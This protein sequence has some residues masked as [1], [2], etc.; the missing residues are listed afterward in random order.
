MHYLFITF[1]VFIGFFVVETFSFY[2]IFKFILIRLRLT[3]K[4]RRGSNQNIWISA[5]LFCLFVCFLVCPF[6]YKILGF[7]QALLVTS[8][9]F[10]IISLYYKEQTL[11]STLI[12]T[13]A[14]EILQKN[15]CFWHF[16]KFSYQIILLPRW[17]LF[18][19]LS[20]PHSYFL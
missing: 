13:S 15:F 5:G 2:V 18:S 19:F 8:K 7:P 14:A 10:Q 9:T 12:P 1:L 3:L 6:P 20:L 4:L 17:Q 16:L 11:L